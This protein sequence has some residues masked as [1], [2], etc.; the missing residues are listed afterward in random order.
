MFTKFW[1]LRHAHG[2]RD[3]NI[4]EL[5]SLNRKKLAWALPI[6]GKVERPHKAWFP[7][8]KCN[9]RKILEHV[10]EC[11]RWPFFGPCVVCVALNFTQAPCVELRVL[12]CLC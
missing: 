5:H 9:A 4:H 1:L 12:R 6:V 2:V 8:A 10:S 7:A 11:L 3:M